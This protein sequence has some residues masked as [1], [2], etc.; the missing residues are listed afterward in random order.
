VSGLGGLS[1]HS[2]KASVK[3]EGMSEEKLRIETCRC[4]VRIWSTIGIQHISD[5]VL[6]ALSG[7]S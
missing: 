6:A 3:S 1:V 5:Y 4:T 7:L 2:V